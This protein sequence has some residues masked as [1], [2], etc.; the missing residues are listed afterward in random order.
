[1]TMEV[2][3]GGRGGPSCL[4]QPNL[5][6]YALPATLVELLPRYR[7][8][9]MEICKERRRLFQNLV[10]AAEVTREPSD[11]PRDAELYLE[12]LRVGRKFG[13]V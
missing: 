7:H 2:A 11:N 6:E 13:L 4:G 1:M 5:A 3:A 9:G 8:F 12:L 10:A